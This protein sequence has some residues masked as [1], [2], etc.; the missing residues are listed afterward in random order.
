MADPLPTR[1][2]PLQNNDVVIQRVDLHG[3]S[4]ASRA[5]R[6][7][8]GPLNLSGILRYRP[9]DSGEQR[10]R[11][12]DGITSTWRCDPGMHAEYLDGRRA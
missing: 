9:K 10:R 8:T 12:R 2:T 7:R 5:I 11:T 6:S 3:A 4:C 1:P